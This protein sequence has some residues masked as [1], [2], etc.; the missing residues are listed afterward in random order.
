MLPPDK[1][2]EIRQQCDRVRTGPSPPASTGT[3]LSSGRRCNKLY[4]IHHD[5]YSREQY[6]STGKCSTAPFETSPCRPSLFLALKGGVGKSA[7]TGFLADFLSSIFGQ[8]VLVVDLDPQ[9]S[10][11]IALLGEERLLGALKRERLLGA[12][13]DGHAG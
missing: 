6:A 4:L 9:Q 8:R 5:G 2:T 3:C 7:I 12:V 11:T 13:A 1:S 10:S